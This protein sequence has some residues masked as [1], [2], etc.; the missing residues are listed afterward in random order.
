MFSMSEI[1][2]FWRKQKE[3]YNLI[4]KKYKDGSVSLFIGPN[5]PRYYPNE[6]QLNLET[7]IEISQEIR[8]VRAG[9]LE[10]TADSGVIFQSKD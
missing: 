4:G 10:L 7:P 6:L 3:R 1:P 2:R 8:E 5:R 9:E